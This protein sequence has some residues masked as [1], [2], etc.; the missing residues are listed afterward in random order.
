[1]LLQMLRCLIIIMTLYCPKPNSCWQLIQRTYVSEV[2]RELK[3]S[4]QRLCGGAWRIVRAMQRRAPWSIWGDRPPWFDPIVNVAC[5][6]AAAWQPL[7]HGGLPPL[8]PVLD[9]SSRPYR[10][11]PRGGRAAL[12]PQPVEGG[13]AGPAPPTRRGDGVSWR[14][15]HRGRGCWCL[16]Q[17][18][19]WFWG[20]PFPV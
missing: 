20:P 4:S 12:L 10:L 1:M 19:A 14:W 15:A 13:G 8:P 17:V 11:G 18:R 9:S 7:P 6:P 2:G 5:L 16:H 3:L